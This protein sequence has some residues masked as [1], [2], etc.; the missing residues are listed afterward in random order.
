VVAAATCVIMFIST[1]QFMY[2]ISY[3]KSFSCNHGVWPFTQN[4]HLDSKQ[5]QSYC[6]DGRDS[7]GD[8]NVIYF[9]CREQFVCPRL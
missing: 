8:V 5:D 4:R 2:I 3:R 9:N 6:R 1:A 7:Y